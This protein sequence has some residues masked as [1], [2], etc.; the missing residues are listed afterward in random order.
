MRFLGM[1]GFYR[2]YCPNFSAVAAPLTRLT[3][4]KVHFEW[5]AECQTSFDHL[6][7]FLARDPVLAAPDFNVPFLLQTD[8][9]DLACG[10][11]LLQEKD[12]ILHPVAYFSAK[13]NRAQRAYKYR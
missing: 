5:T 10:A 12:G 7:T 2:Q 3:S 6:K 4:G 8:A 1:A 11:V 13:F 9:S